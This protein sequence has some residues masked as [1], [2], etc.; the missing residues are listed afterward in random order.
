MLD[1]DSND[2][3]SPR[4]AWNKQLPN[5]GVSLP[6]CRDVGQIKYLTVW[7]I[8]VKP[9]RMHELGRRS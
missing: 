4:S 3:A 6:R 9:A 8:G 1:D 5:L 2:R 7:L